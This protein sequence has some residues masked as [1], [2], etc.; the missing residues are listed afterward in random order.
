MTHTAH[1]CEE[2]GSAQHPA[3]DPLRRASDAISGAI[4]RAM[5]ETTT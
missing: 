3:T 4:A 2:E 1:G 5:G